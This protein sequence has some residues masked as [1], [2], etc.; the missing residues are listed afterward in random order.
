MSQAPRKAP[1]LASIHKAREERG[2]GKFTRPT[3]TAFLYVALAMGAILFGYRFFA[4]R[5]LDNAKAQLL[6]KQRAAEVEL[7]AR[8]FPLRDHLEAT[9]LSAAKDFGDDHVDPGVASWDFRAMPGLYLRLRVADARDAATLRRAAS[10]SLRDGFIGCLARQGGPAAEHVT[11]AMGLADAGASAAQPW[12]L[13]Q[14]YAATRILSEDWVR[15]VKEAGDDLRLRVFEQ[16]YEK[17]VREEVGL[18]ADIVT[19]ARYFL[20]VL[21]EDVDEAKEL[22]DGGAITAETLQLVGHPSR[23]LVMDLKGRKEMA[24]LRRTGSASFVFAGENTVTD[25]ET[26]HAMQ[27]QVNNCSLAQQVRDALYPKTN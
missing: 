14:A 15:E 22:A 9:T 4:G 26:R 24:R 7:G 13:R 16:Q 6:S 10:E 19:R 27:R 25:E 1:G 8:W 11:A 3:G 18:A 2:R 23:V 21:D 12:N 17:A 20:L 5:S